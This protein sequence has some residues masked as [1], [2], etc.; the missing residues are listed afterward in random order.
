MTTFTTS[1]IDLVLFNHKYP[2][3]KNLGLHATEGVHNE[4]RQQNRKQ[5]CNHHSLRPF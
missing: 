1:P 4:Y 3:L 2:K 5:R